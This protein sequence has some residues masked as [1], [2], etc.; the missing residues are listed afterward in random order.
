MGEKLAELMDKYSD[1]IEKPT[2]NQYDLSKEMSGLIQK[3]EDNLDH[4]YILN[5]MFGKE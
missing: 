5:N 2:E 4:H 3:N 1:M